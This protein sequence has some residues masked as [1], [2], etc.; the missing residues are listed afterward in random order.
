[1]A[2]RII[3]KGVGNKAGEIKLAGEE[4]RSKKERKREAGKDNL[5]YK[6][7]QSINLCY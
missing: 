1:M 3:E 6:H 7:H 5:M 4:M 2:R